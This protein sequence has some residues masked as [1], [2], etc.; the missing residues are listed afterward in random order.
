MK[1]PLLMSKKVYQRYYIDKNFKNFVSDAIGKF[2][3][4]DW[5]EV[6]EAD[7]EDNEK[8]IIEKREV[9][10]LYRDKRNNN[11]VIIILPAHRKNLD[12][13]MHEELLEDK[14]APLII[15]PYNQRIPN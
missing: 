5:G 4:K 2:G 6:E 13:F 1:I 9:V 3:K 12:I 14:P 15:T 10:G 11:E 7:K 8:A